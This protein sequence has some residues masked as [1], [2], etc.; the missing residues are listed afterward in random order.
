MKIGLK[1]A[2]LL[3]ADPRLLFA[4]LL[5]TPKEEVLSVAVLLFSAPVPKA[6]LPSLKVTVPL[7]VPP[8]CALTVA[9]KVRDCLK[10]AGLLPAV[11]ARTVLVPDGLTVWLSDGLVLPWKLVSP[12]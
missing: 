5:A 11:R 12:L 6:V 7:G 4:I 3:N 2:P 9:V 8:N 1:P 10:V